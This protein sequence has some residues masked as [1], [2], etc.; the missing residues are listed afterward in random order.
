MNLRLLISVLREQQ[1]FKPG[2]VESAFDNA[3]AGLPSLPGLPSFLK[4]VACLYVAKAKGLDTFMST[5]PECS[6]CYSAYCVT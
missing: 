1:Q 3:A 2:D 5:D 6:E 4:C